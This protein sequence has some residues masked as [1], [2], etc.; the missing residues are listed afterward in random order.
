MANEPQTRERGDGGPAGSPGKAAF[1]R[2]TAGLAL[3]FLAPLFGIIAVA[4]RLEDSGPVFYR[5]WRPGLHGRP[6]R[7]YKFRTMIPDAERVGTGMK[8]SR[9]DPRITRVGRLLRQTSLDEL[10][11]LINVLQGDMSVIGPRP[12]LPAQADRYTPRQRRRLETRPG[13]TG[14]AQVTGRN[15]LTW[16]ERIERDIWYID[17]WSLLL[18]LQILARTP[19]AMINPRGIYGSGGE[20]RDLGE[21]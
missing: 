18:D 8:T 7:I 12:G 6:F 13:I 14:W 17:N 11:Q 20:T 3:A 19:W 10:P 4:I 9:H 16:E 15:D 21:K 5:Q 2:L 1:D